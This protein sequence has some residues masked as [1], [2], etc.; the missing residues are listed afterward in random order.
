MILYVSSEEEQ[1][2]LPETSPLRKRRPDRILGFQHTDNFESQLNEIARNLQDEA[3]TKIIREMVETTV[4][5]HK[6]KLLLFPFLVMEAKA[7]DGKGLHACDIQT[8]LPIWKMLRIQEELQAKTKKS[9]DYGGPLWWY[10]TYQG[11]NWQVSGCY[12]AE[13]RGKPSYVS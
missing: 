9:L 4:V 11:K 8:S 6:N 2:K 12:T 5:N 10:I 13:N 3:G 1:K 7:E